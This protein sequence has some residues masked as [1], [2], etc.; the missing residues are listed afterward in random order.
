MKE[1]NDKKMMHYVYSQEA[2][3]KHGYFIGEHVDG[4]IIVFTAIM[5]NP[6]DYI[7][8]DK[9]TVI[10][11]DED[12]KEVKITTYP[13]K[14]KN[15]KQFTFEH[16]PSSDIRRAIDQYNAMTPFERASIVKMMKKIEATSTQKNKM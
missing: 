10:V 7:F 11:T 15:I 12:S 1:N 16:D 9:K 2:A 6:E 5:Q 3:D 8:K 4:S 13:D 14:T